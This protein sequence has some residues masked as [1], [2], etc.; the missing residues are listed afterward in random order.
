MTNMIKEKS[1][2]QMRRVIFQMICGKDNDMMNI[3]VRKKKYERKIGKKHE[4]IWN[5]DEFAI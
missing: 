2:R 4:K 5:N 3:Y 1:E